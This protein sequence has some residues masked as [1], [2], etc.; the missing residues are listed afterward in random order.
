MYPQV[1]QYLEA[2]SVDAANPPLEEVHQDIDAQP[3]SKIF[4]RIWPPLFVDRGVD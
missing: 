2:L 4:Q 1:L 3:P